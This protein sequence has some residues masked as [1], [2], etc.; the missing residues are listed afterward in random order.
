MKLSWQSFNI[1]QETHRRSRFKFFRYGF[2]FV[3]RRLYRQDVF[4]FFLRIDISPLPSPFTIVPPD[5]SFFSGKKFINSRILFL[6]PI[7]RVISTFGSPTVFYSF[8]FCL[9]SLACALLFDLA[10]SIYLP[11][12][13]FLENESFAMELL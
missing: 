1:K 3:K 11:S 4:F 8:V 9:I 7:N 12:F 6:S 13:P 2:Q 10:Y 5:D